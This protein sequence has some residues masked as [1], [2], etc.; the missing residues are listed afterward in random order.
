VA[1]RGDAE[2]LKASVRKDVQV[3]ILPPLPTACA[4]PDLSASQL[5]PYN[6]LLGVYLGDGY[7]N[8]C[9]R[10]FRLEIYLNAKDT[11]GIRQTADAMRAL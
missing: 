3:R 11:R 7:I 10:T 6:Y 2:A 5:R 1:E 8:R 9:P 4:S